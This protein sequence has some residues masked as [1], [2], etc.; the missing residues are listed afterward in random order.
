M[1]SA[2]PLD[3]SDIFLQPSV[4]LG[5]LSAISAAHTIRPQLPL[6]AAHMGQLQTP[7]PAAHPGQSQV[8]L[9]AAY[10]S[11]PQVSLAAHGNFSALSI[12]QLS[13]PESTF[14]GSFKKA[15][16]NF[17]STQDLTDL[18]ASIPPSPVYKPSSALSAPV[19]LDY[20]VETRFSFPIPKSKTFEVEAGIF[21][22]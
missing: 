8:P 5:P 15:F 22:I 13:S 2:P 14:F 9:P 3:P 6:P 17:F 19:G 20:S 21:N 7:M 4:D 16:V 18:S 1:P 10:P 12:T 11:R